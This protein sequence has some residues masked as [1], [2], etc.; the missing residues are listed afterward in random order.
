MLSLAF[1]RVVGM[2]FIELLVLCCFALWVLWS[3]LRMVLR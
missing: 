1:L 3:V 2:V